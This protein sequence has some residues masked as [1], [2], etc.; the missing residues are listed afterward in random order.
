MPSNPVLNRVLLC[1]VT[2]QALGASTC[3]CELGR[4]CNL[5]LLS[6]KSEVV[7]WRSMHERMR[8]ACRRTDMMWKRWNFSTRKT[9]NQLYPHMSTSREAIKYLN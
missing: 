8:H 2:L 6:T 7:L 5:Y 9:V 3:D 4:V 1:Y